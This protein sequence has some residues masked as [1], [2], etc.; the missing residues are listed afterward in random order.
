MKQDFDEQYRNLHQ[1]EDE[2]HQ[3]DAKD[4]VAMII[5]MLQLVM[6]IALAFMGAALAIMLLFKF[7]FG[8]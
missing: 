8:S 4:V 6:P 2:G 3:L 1:K 5:A 7:L